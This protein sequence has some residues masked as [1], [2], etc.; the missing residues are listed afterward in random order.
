[1]VKYFF[2]ICCMRKYD[3]PNMESNILRFISN[4]ESIQQFNGD[5]GKYLL[6]STKEKNKYIYCL[7]FQCLDPIELI[8]LIKDIKGSNFY[9]SFITKENEGNELL[10][11]YNNLAYYEEMG[12]ELRNTYRTHIKILRETSGNDLHLHLVLTNSTKLN[13][14]TN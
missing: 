12:V 3:Y 6:V 8:N 14:L 9:I 5:I 2:D 11:I 1:M 4:F 13:I 10:Y 7:Y